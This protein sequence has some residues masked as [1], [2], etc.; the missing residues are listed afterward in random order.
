MMP[1]YPPVIK[2]LLQG[3][4]SLWDYIMHSSVLE[5]ASPT[6][7]RTERGRG[8]ERRERERASHERLSP[9]HLKPDLYLL[10]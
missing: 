4:E 1:A 7:W 2:P 3:V 6:G 5:W 10:S 9:F 8:R